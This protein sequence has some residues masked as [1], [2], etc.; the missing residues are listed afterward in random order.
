[1]FII[2]ISTK[3]VLVTFFKKVSRMIL[4]GALL[5]TIGCASVSNFQTGKPLGKGNAQGYAAISH[6]TT[7]GASIK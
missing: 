3:E 7:K 6:I 5:L 2:I 1:L 4:S